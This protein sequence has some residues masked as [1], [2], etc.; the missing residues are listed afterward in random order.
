MFEFQGERFIQLLHTI[1][2]NELVGQPSVHSSYLEKHV[3][4]P[5]QKTG[6]V[7]LSELDWSAFG[8]DE[9]TPAGYWA[10]YAKVRMGW[11]QSLAYCFQKIASLPCDMKTFF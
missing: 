7:K 4:Q 1:P 5:L 8:I 10:Q 3:F 9:T 6:G 11:C 2:E